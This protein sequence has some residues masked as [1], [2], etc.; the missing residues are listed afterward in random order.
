MFVISL[1]LWD[2]DGCRSQGLGL[3]R[4]AGRGD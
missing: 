3:N 2:T 1:L 4:F